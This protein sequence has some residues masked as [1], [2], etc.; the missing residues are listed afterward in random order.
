[1]NNNIMIIDD[2]RDNIRLATMVLKKEGYSVFSALSVMEGIEIMRQLNI[3]L[4]I[5]DIM[6]PDI[7]GISGINLIKQEK[8]LESVPI[9]MLTAISTR[10]YV[11]KAFNAGANDYMKKPYNLDTL[12]SKTKNL[13]NTDEIIENIDMDNVI[14]LDNIS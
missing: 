10:D 12:V 2:N 1:M 14:V 4:I 8:E 11:L 13:I 3:S 7:D 5:L 9:L 6:M